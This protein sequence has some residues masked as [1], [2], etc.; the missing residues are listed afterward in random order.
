MQADNGVADFLKYPKLLRQVIKS[1]QDYIDSHPQCGA[2]KK[3]LNAYGVIYHNLFC[4][5]YD[6]YRTVMSPGLFDECF[7]PEKAIKD[8]FKI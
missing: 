1:I 8:Y 7:N 4:N 5:S 6:E 2:K 3:F